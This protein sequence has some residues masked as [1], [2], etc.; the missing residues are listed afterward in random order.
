MSTRRQNKRIIQDLLRNIGEDRR[1]VDS[2][3]GSRARVSSQD[4]YAYAEKSAENIRSLLNIARGRNNRPQAA[5][6]QKS[7]GQS[8]AAS[9]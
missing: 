4:L 3:V 1:F 6:T 2:V 5:K 7:N 9:A 8:S